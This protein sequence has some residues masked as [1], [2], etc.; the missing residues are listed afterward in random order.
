[1]L[2]FSSAARRSSLSFSVLLCPSLSFSSAARRLLHSPP[3]ARPV[4]QNDLQAMARSHRLGQT[5]TVKVFRLVMRHSYEEELVKSANLKLGLERAMHAASTSAE[6]EDGGAGEGGGVRAGPPRDRLAVERMLRCGAQNIALDD[7]SAF[8]QFSEADIDSLLES[9]SSS[10]TTLQT[11]AGGS[12]FSKVSFSE[13]LRASPQA[14][15]KLPTSCPHASPQASP[16]A[17]PLA[18]RKLAR[19]VSHIARASRWR[20]R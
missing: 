9:S 14:S 13:L 17:S 1:M 2:S 16:L 5:K 11:A 10:R 7:D 19:S 12:S 20:P 8:Q 15:H 6:G 18:S 4:H 3:R